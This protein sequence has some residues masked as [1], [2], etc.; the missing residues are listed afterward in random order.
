MASLMFALW[1]G[2]E[3][4]QWVFIMSDTVEPPSLWGLQRMVP[5]GNSRHQGR[6][7]NTDTQ[8]KAMPS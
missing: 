1:R 5:S 3:C 4:R 2:Y 8:R 6:L 7:T